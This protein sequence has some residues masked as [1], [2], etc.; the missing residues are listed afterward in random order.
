MS[1]PRNLTPSAP[2]ATV[3]TADPRL[4]WSLDRER[5]TDAS[6]VG[7]AAGPDVGMSDPAELRLAVEP[8]PAGEGWC[9]ARL[10]SPETDGSLENFWPI[11]AVLWGTL[12][13]NRRFSGEPSALRGASPEKR[14]EK[15]PAIPA[16]WS[17][18]SREA[19][20]SNKNGTP[21]GAPGPPKS[22]K[23]RALRAHAPSASPM[24]GVWPRSPPRRVRQAIHDAREIGEIDAGE[25]GG[26]EA[27]AALERR[28]SARRPMHSCEARCGARGAKRARGR[29]TRT[30]GGP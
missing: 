17:R 8:A 2:P 19:T 27:A 28:R 5:K 9:P 16:P 13:Q 23:R 6:G 15:T 21:K 20:P 22:L 11:A 24:R 14:E 26:G 18:F 3:L 25:P 29:R 4:S 7:L 30:H 10:R 1:L 12:G